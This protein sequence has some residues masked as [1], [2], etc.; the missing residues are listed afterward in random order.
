MKKYNVSVAASPLQLLNCIEAIHHFKMRNN[1][2]ILL[3]TT[4]TQSLSQM[5]KLMLFIEWEN[6]YYV[7]LPEKVL[8]K[9]F[10]SKI[11]E[12]SLK[13]IEKGKI[14]SLV[15]GEYQSTHVHHIVNYLNNKNIY[16]VDDGM[17]LLSYNVYRKNKTIKQKVIK[18]VYQ[19]LFYKLKDIK[20]KLFTIFEIEDSSTIKNEYTFFKNYINQVERSD[21]VYF[22]G[23]P[24]IELNLMEEKTYITELRKILKFYNKKKFVYILHRRQDESLIKQ[25]SAALQFEYKKFD[26]LI[27]LEMLSSAKVPLY[28]ATFFSTAIL[29]LP[30]FIENATYCAFKIENQ[31]FINQSRERDEELASFYA[32]FI[33]NNIKVESL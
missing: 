11:I 10:F 1:I 30:K 18:L 6:I 28:F 15:V 19:F 32:E 27:E 17:S 20:Y 7:S 16:L 4:N 2:L 8:E 5:E 3:K 26:N 13:E 9:L 31:K 23:Q 12:T 25:I 21:E 22:I 33:K 14:Q 24:L 29:T